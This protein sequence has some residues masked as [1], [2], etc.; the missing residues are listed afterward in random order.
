M[1]FFILSFFFLQN[2]EVPFKP[3]DEFEVKIDLK[4]KTRNIS[5][6]STGAVDLAETNDRKAKRMSG[7]K[8]YLKLNL[9]LLKVSEDEVKMEI[10]NTFGA[11]IFSKKTSLGHTIAIDMGYVDD[12]KDHTVANGFNVYFVSSEKKIV[13]RI[14]ILIEKD[15]SYVING[16]VYGKF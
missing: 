4:F 2:P 9:R 15:G 3:A 5:S 10:F 12:I 13:R 11:R 6:E 1:I 14:A 7:P 16:A 8:G